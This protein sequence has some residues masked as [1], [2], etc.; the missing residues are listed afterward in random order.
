M[1]DNTT[2]DSTPQQPEGETAPIGA[3]S[4]NRWE[5]AAYETTADPAAPAA[6][7]VENVAP[8]PPVG[9]PPVLPQEPARSRRPSRTALLAGGAAAALVLVGAGAFAA[10]HAAADGGRHDEQF[11]VDQFGQHTGPPPGAPGQ[12]TLPGGPDG[13]DDHGFGDFDDDGGES[14]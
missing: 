2:P 8:V 5:A 14:E 7:V 1:P 4:G 9:Q 10:G 13:D 11:Q 6:P 12:G 3:A